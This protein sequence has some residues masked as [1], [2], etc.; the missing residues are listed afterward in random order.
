MQQTSGYTFSQNS[1]VIC[2]KCCLNSVLIS[3]DYPIFGNWNLFVSVTSIN[4]NGTDMRM[5]MFALSYC[6]APLFDNILDW[7]PFSGN[8][9]S[10]SN[11]K[12]TENKGPHSILHELRRLDCSWMY[13]LFWL[14]TTPRSW[15]SVWSSNTNATQC[16]ST[17]AYQNTALKTATGCI[18]VIT[19]FI[20]STCLGVT[21]GVILTIMWWIK[22]PHSGVS[23]STYRI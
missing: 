1:R 18:L 9:V 13:R 15:G 7:T 4:F 8:S 22:L 10:T 5:R 21:L 11:E 20:C 23:R 16:G 19:Y 12:K 3:Q 17:Q 2:L 6:Q 14:K